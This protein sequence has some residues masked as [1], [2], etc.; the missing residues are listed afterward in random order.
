MR[1]LAEPVG[2][3]AGAP[4]ARPDSPARG[5]SISNAGELSTWQLTKLHEQVQAATSTAERLVAGRDKRDLSVRRHST[6]WSV[7]ECL[8][9]LTQTAYT[10]LPAIADT[11]THAPRLATNQSFRTGVLAELLIRHLEPPYRIRVKALPQL[12]PQRTEFADAWSAF[13]EAQSQFSQTVRSSDGFAID[14]VKITC[15]IYARVH[16]NAYGAL[17]MLVAHERRHLWQIQQILGA[18]DRTEHQAES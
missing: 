13:L 5:V 12:M 1:I 16:Y 7:S 18:L 10:F 8:D 9:H 15:P 17:R 6:A 3:S 4:F 2:C 11:V 14:R